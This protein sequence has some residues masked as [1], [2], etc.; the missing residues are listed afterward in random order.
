[1]PHLLSSWL[2]CYAVLTFFLVSG[3]MIAVSVHRHRTADRFDQWR[4]LRARVLRI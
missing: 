4:F 2:A 3:F 1:M